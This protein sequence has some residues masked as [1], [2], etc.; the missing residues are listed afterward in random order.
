MKKSSQSKSQGSEKTGN[1][2]GL[3]VDVIEGWRMH[4]TE[5]LLLSYLVGDTICGGFKVL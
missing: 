2:T 1:A 5:H 4:F 3:A